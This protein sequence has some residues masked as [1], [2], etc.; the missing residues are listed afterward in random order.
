M[1]F[2]KPIVQ[3]EVTEGRRSALEA[4]L[5][6]KANDTRDMA[7]KI[8]GL[9]KDPETCAKMGEYGRARVQAELSWEHQTETLVA[10]YQRVAEK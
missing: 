8:A 6:A 5:Y 2:S 3:F 9:L 4:S 7:E 1:A 10:A